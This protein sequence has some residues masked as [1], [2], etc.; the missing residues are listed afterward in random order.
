[1]R[2]L[3]LNLHLLLNKSQYKGTFNFE[4]EIETETGTETS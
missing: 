4:T 1:M 2:S 3:Q